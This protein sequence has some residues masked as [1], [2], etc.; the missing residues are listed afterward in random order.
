M[1]VKCLEKK[2]LVWKK[3]LECKLRGPAHTDTDTRLHLDTDC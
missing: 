1:G 2:G 3:L